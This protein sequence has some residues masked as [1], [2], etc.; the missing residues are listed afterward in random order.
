MDIIIAGAGRVGFRLAETLS[1]HHD[2]YIV[3]RNKEALSK[4][5][6]TIDYQF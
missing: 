4:L 2:I 1:L 6:E 5:E 3:D